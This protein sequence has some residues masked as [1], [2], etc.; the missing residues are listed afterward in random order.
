MALPAVV[1]TAVAVIDAALKVAEAV[2]KVVAFFSPTPSSAYNEEV[3]KLDQLL[4]D[5][6][7]FRNEVREMGQ[8]IL[9]AIDHTRQTIQLFELNRMYSL[10][11]SALHS[12][13]TARIT[14]SQNL[15]DA[16]LRDSD[17]AV[18]ELK[19]AQAFADRVAAIGPFLFVV[20]ARLQIVAELAN[21]SFADAAFQRQ[22]D[23]W[24]SIVRQ[25]AGIIESSIRHV[26]GLRKY[27]KHD[28]IGRE[29]RC[30]IDPDS[31]RR[32]CQWVGEGRQHTF[33]SYSNISETVNY[34]YDSEDSSVGR[35]QPY[36]NFPAALEAGVQADL[37][38][39]GI[40][41]MRKIADTWESTKRISKFHSAWD[42]IFDRQLTFSEYGAILNASMKGDIDLKQVAEGLMKT[43]EFHYLIGFTPDASSSDVVTGAFQRVVGRPP[44]PEESRIHSELLDKFGYGTFAA[45]VSTLV[46]APSEKNFEDKASPAIAQETFETTLDVFR[47]L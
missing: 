9:L 28:T 14:N 2:Q 12:L 36:N 24:V 3:R 6:I 4:T 30:E 5:F 25:A 22:I 1:V 27:E 29:Y 35:G 43:K 42:H 7:N 15:R 31:H 18:T 44:D 47:K 46:E 39:Y 16:A 32:V 40:N 17:T 23:D 20:H 41:K 26:N 38:Q 10:A 11:E 8:T 19:N 33:I 37:E 34:V 13:Q 21:G 45:A